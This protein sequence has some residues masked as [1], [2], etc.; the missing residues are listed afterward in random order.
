MLLD[1]L[2]LT[3]ESSSSAM[4]HHRGDPKSDACPNS[5]ILITMKNRNFEKFK[6][7]NT[8]ED[9][10]A[11][12]KKL[13]VAVVMVKL[14]YKIGE[15]SKVLTRIPEGADYFTVVPLKHVSRYAM[16]VTG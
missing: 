12:P 15:S 16:L 5:D 7:D 9:V 3:L 2:L 14:A 1:A 4:C 8:M 13:R 6:K 10:K 11:P